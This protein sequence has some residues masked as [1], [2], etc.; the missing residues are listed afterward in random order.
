MIRGRGSSDDKGQLMTFVEACRA[1]KAVHGTL[2][3][4]ITMFFEGEEKSGSPSPSLHRFNAT[5]LLKADLALIC[6]TGLFDRDTPAITTMLRG[7]VGEVFTITGPRMDL[8]S[9]R[10]RRRRDQPDPGARP[11]HRLAPRRGRARHPA[12]LL[13]RRARAPERPSAQW[14]GLG[15][16]EAAFLGDVGLSVPAGERGA[17]RAGVGL[18]AARP[19]R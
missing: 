11:D 3:A 5:D 7:L 4:R 10:L 12:R 9:G 14:D 8:H 16:D 6:D 15:F 2:P 1:W 13:R 18:G 19:A 17:R